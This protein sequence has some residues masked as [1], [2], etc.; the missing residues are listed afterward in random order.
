MALTEQEK[1]IVEF[2]KNENKSRE[3]ILDALEG[4][5]TAQRGQTRIR[6]TVEDI[7]ETV[8]EVVGQFRVA[9]EKIVE[10][11]TA[12]D[13]DILEKTLGIGAEV[14]R[15][16]SR[17]FGETVI[18]IGKVLLPQSIEDKISGIVGEVGQFIGEQPITQDLISRYNALGPEERRNVDNVLGFA[19]GLADIFTFRAAGTIS[20]KA[21]SVAVKGV[22]GAS[23]LTKRTTRLIRNTTPKSIRSFHNRLTPGSREAA[24]S[25]LSDSYIKSFVVD[26]PSVNRMLEKQARG[27]TRADGTKVTKE[28]LVRGLAEEG[29][30]PIV[31]GKL[32]KFDRVIDNLSERQARIAESIDPLL[33]TVPQITTLSSLRSRAAQVL[34]GSPQIGADLTA[35]LKEL[36]R[37]FDSFKTKYGDNLSALE[38]NE[39]R[40]QMN[41]R[42]RA[43][44]DDAF[45]QDTADAVADA[46]R[47]RIDEIVES[48]IVRQANAEIGKLFGL[49]RTAEIFNNR[50]INVGVFGGQM[51]RYIGVVGASGIGFTAGGP[52][53][54]VVAGIAASYGGEVV[55]KILRDRAFSNK[56]RKVIIEGIKQDD[57]IVKRLIA[58][59][60]G[61]NKAFLERV[62]LP[63]PAETPIPLPVRRFDPIREKQFV[64]RAIKEIEAQATRSKMQFTLQDQAK[65]FKSKETFIKTVQNNPSWLKKFEEAGTTLESIAGIVF[66]GT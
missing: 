37:F 28:N 8:G 65:R 49:K 34:R 63:S 16:G 5:R 12:K 51:G 23:K 18:G 57:E 43:F 66:G 42:T 61:A 22:D 15:R 17:V 60:E 35:S 14:F 25:S 30:I 55:A 59:A 50:T 31:E 4:F 6:E 10:T 3:E 56:I 40:K 32:A 11:A 47:I 62:L 27:R 58:E 46:T 20:R 52:G 19:E 53:G 2:G 38:V 36:D 9:G 7:R 24:V 33:A 39:I 26:S 29:Y 64:E 48:G 21:I 1:Q 41:R 44:G 45:K 54:L 13:L